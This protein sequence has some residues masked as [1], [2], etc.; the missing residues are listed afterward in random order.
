MTSYSVF[1]RYYDALTQNVG[2]RARCDQLCMLLERHHAHPRLV[3]DLACGTGSMTLELARR[4]FEPIGVDASSAMLSEA[5]QKASAAHANILFLCQKMQQ[6]DLYGTVEAVFCTLDSVNHLT[7]PEW[8]KET[9]RRVA[10]FL[11]PG[12]LFLFDVNTPYKH[13]TVLGNQTFVLE[14]DS[15]FCAWQN[16]LQADRMTVQIQLDFFERHG[17]SYTRSTERFRERAYEL[18]ELRLWLQEAGLTCLECCAEQTLAEP[19]PDTQR[20]I[21]VAQKGIG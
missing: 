4:G 11:E 20:V 3:L 13:Q 5:Q 19:Q 9:F 2:Y 16:E 12:G 7:R 18:D 14:T 10:L 15:V 6:L 17:T 21:F 1:S 8:V